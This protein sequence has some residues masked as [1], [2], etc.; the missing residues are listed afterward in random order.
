MLGADPLAGAI[1]ELLKAADHEAF[2][3][4]LPRLRAAFDRLHERQRATLAERV[5]IRYGLKKADVIV[6][7]G[8]SVAAGAL[9]ARIDE[10]T[11]RVLA[12]WDL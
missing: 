3:I 1:D 7:L 2:L 4:M 9:M 5:A 12:E 6:R 10:Q 8:T 11:G